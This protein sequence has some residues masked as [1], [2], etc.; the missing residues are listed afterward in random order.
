MDA[1]VLDLEFGVSSEK[2]PEMEFLSPPCLLLTALILKSV[3]SDT[4]IATPAFLFLYFYFYEISFPSL[5][6]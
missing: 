6:F 3:L 5:D 2:Y 4:R 1:Y